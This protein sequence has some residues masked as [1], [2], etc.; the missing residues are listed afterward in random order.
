MISNSYPL[1]M[2]SRSLRMRVCFGSSGVL[3]VPVV[4]VTS[5]EVSFEGTL[6]EDG[7]SFIF[8]EELSFS[9]W[10][11]LEVESISLAEMT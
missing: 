9:A 6:D 11:C 1:R 10:F 2:F 5:R 3:T 8:V 4:G 7:E